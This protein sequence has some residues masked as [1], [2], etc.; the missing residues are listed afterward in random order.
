MSL[1]FA[2][3]LFYIHKDAAEFNLTVISQLFM[4]PDL[5]HNKKHWKSKDN[6]LWKVDD[7]TGTESSNL[8]VT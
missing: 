5:I 2:F 4:L 8:C 1:D 7:Q 6:I 3:F